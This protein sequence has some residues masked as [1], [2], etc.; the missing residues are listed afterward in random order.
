[1]SAQ[2]MR[3]QTATQLKQGEGDCDISNSLPFA[4]P[5]IKSPIRAIYTYII[6]LFLAIFEAHLLPLVHR[7]GLCGICELLGILEGVGAAPPDG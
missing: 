6:A 4:L 3:R 5:A 1:M 7:G 2:H